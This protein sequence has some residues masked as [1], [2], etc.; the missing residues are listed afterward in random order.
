MKNLLNLGVSDPLTLG[1]AHPVADRLERLG[2]AR[3][4]TWRNRCLALSAMSVIA[5]STAPLSIAAD[6]LAVENSG[7]KLTVVPD[8]SEAQLA[9]LQTRLDAV[10]TGQA[11]ES[12]VTDFMEENKGHLEVKYNADGRVTEIDTTI[13]NSRTKEVMGSTDALLERCKTEKTGSL[14]A[15]RKSFSWGTANVE[16]VTLS[17]AKPELGNEI[18]EAKADIAALME[19]SD[20]DMS[21]KM[22]RARGRMAR[23]MIAKTKRE[24]PEPTPQEVYDNCVKDIDYV[25]KNYPYESSPPYDP[26]SALKTCA[27]YKPE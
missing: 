4:A 21:T 10:S 3:P 11:D 13:G 12:F 5:I 18:E 19:S 7:Y 14:Y 26:A 24:F 1:M 17:D 2:R 27:K 6:D 9:E 15:M 16:C 25:N 20:L 22:A 23:A 8:M